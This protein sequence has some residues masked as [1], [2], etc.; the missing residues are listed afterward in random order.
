MSATLQVINFVNEAAD[1]KNYK[2]IR[3]TSANDHVIRMSVMT[4]AF[5]W[6]YHPNT[7]ETFL[8]IEGILIIDLEESTLELTPGELVTIPAGLKHRTRPGG[9]RSV[10]LTFELAELQTIKC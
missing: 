2:N 8:V 10:N 1:I 5:Y 7:D 3:L 4:E 9:G 6:H